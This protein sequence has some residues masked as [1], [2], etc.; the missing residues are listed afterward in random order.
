MADIYTVFYTDDAEY[1]INYKQFTDRENMKKFILKIEK[2]LT[3][4]YI[5]PGEIED[6]VD[7]EVKYKNNNPNGEPVAIYFEDEVEYVPPWKR[8]Y[9]E[10]INDEEI[11][12][13]EK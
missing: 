11:N 4:C 9:N 12:D 2:Q 3:F 8:N 10:E 6:F 7:Y 5:L 1:N 13:E